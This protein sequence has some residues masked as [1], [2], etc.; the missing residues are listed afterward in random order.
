[1]SDSSA[2]GPLVGIRVLDRTYVLVGPFLPYC[3]LCGQL[4]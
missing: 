2:Q 4:L 3:S 1:M